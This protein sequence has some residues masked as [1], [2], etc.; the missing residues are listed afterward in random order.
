MPRSLL[1][2]NDYVFYV[3]REEAVNFTVRLA[4][5][6][7]IEIKDI[8]NWIRRNSIKY[9]RFDSMSSEERA[10]WLGVV[11]GSLT[12]WPRLIALLEEFWSG[13]GDG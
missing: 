1:T 9:G 12:Y 3:E 6:D 4:S 5:G 10:H 11:E 2:I 13:D 7:E 8:S